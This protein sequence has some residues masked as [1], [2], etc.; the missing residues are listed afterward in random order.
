MQK[1]FET[2]VSLIM[3]CYNSEKLIK[4]PFEAILRQQGNV[5][6]EMIIVDNNCTD[7]TVA[8]IKK[9]Y[10]ESGSSTHLTIVKEPKLGVGYARKKGFLKAKYTYI[11]FIDDDNIISNNWVNTIHGLFQK[12]PEIGIIGSSNKALFLDGNEP[13][14]FDQVKG[15]YACA[16]QGNDLEELTY[17]R[18][19][20]YGAGMSFRKEVSDNVY[21]LPIPFY[22]I[23]RKGKKLFRW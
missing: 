18:K 5:L 23:G 1:E 3:C 13:E 12:N 19:Y 22:L 21:S 8:L 17:T 4:K 9:I 6:Y 16:S 14:W 11:S 7:N 2:G 15:A 10:E 20:V